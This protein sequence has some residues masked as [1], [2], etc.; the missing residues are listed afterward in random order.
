MQKRPCQM[1]AMG[2]KRIEQRTCPSGAYG[3]VPEVSSEEKTFASDAPSA[4][5]SHSRVLPGCL[6][7]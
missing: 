4:C 6:L 3:G 2:C 5:V 1:V 7:G